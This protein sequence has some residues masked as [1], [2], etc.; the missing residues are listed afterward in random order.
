[1]DNNWADLVKVR[2]I[3]E[4]YHIKPVEQMATMSFTVIE[5]EYC[6]CK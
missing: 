1:M 4:H 2:I 5:P 3:S 6:Y